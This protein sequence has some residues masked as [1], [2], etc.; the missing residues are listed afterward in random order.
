VQSRFAD[1]DLFVKTLTQMG[2][3]LKRRDEGGKMFILLD[4]IKVQKN[5]K[6][7]DPSGAL[8]KACTYKKR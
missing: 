1:V 8:L 2:F 3:K 5:V 4:F 7:V 6:R